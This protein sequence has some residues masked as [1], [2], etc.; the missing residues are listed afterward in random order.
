[1][2]L[3][4][5]PEYF[6]SHASAEVRGENTPE[7]KFASTMDWTHNH[8]V[9]SQTRSPLSHPGGAIV[10]N[11]LIDRCFAPLSTFFKSNHGDNSNYSCLSWAGLWSVLFKNTHLMRV[12]A[13]SPGLRVKHFTT[14]IRR[15]RG[16]QTETETEVGDWFG[17]VYKASAES[18]CLHRGNFPN[19]KSAEFKIT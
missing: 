2:D 19:R 13:R 3:W 17:A 1:M 5:V 9:M 6:F 7:R 4:T 18:I 15:I 12:V 10:I 11:W 16:R 14:E 8:Q